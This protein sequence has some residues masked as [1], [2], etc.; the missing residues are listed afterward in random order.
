MAKSGK[1]KPADGEPKVRIIAKN[2]KALHD[3]KI[4]DQLECG[5]EKP[6]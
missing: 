4:L 2:R 6:P 1:N 5:R 3:Y